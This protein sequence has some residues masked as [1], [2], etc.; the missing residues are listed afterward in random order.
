LRELGATF[1]RVRG[2]VELVSGPS[3]KGPAGLTARAT[4]VLELAGEAARRYA[5]GRVGTIHLLLGLVDEGENTAMS[6]LRS[7]DLSAAQVRQAAERRL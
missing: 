4:R 5:A 2:V 7:L 1:E 3:G 6:V